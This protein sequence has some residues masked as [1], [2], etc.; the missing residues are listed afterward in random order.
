MKKFVFSLA[1]V[2]K[3][4]RS[5]EDE[6]KNQLA[7]NSSNI[8]LCDQL[9]AELEEEL[10]N[11]SKKH[12]KELKSG[13]SVQKVQAYGFYFLNYNNTK[14]DLLLKK[15][16]LLLLRQELQKK[17]L[18]VMNEIKALDNIYE[19][20]LDEYKKEL[21]IEEDKE[22][23]NNLSFKIYTDVLPEA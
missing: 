10:K 14:K 20:E 3:L 13:T 2:Y 11:E 7:Q 22:I 12:Q 1:S 23:D 16:R 17:L 18:Q 4:K 5:N 9:M 19:K 8:T 15:E 6:L 21:K